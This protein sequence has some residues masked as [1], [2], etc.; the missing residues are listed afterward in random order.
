MPKGSMKRFNGS[1]DITTWIG[2]PW[3]FRAKD[4]GRLMLYYVPYRVIPVIYM[5][6]NESS[7]NEDD[8]TG[9]H[10]FSIVTTKNIEDMCAIQDNLFPY[11]PNSITSINQALD[12]SIQQ[13]ER[14]QVSPRILLKYVYNIALHPSESKYRQIRVANKVFWNNVWCNGGRGVLH[15]LGFEENGSYIEMGRVGN[16]PGDR[17][18]DVSNG[19]VMLEEFMNDIE[20]TDKPAIRQPRGADGSGT[21][22]ANWRM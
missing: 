1:I 11:P 9:V 17:V 3:V 10:A 16:L 20:D 13:M 14:E 6:Q 7:H 8:E 12:F 4:S 5:Q 2:H 21:G 18:K 19:I 22:R 15:A